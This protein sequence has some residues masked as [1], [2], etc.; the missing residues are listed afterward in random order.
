MN[1]SFQGFSADE[2]ALLRG[3]LCKLLGIATKQ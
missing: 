1:R 2:V 3:L